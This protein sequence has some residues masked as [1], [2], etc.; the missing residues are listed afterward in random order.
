[1]IDIANKYES[2]PVLGKEAVSDDIR[3]NVQLFFLVVACVFVC[4]RFFG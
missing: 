2:D 3:L 1:M 4:K